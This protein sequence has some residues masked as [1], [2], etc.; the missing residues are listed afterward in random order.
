MTLTG[1]FDDMTLPVDSDKVTLDF[2]GL[3][4]KRQA[5]FTTFYRFPSS[6]KRP[7]SWLLAP[8]GIPLPYGSFP[9]NYPDKYFNTFEGKRRLLVYRQALL[10]G[11]KAATR[12]TTYLDRVYDIRQQENKCLTD[13]F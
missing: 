13:F 5:M 12:Q 3:I 8:Q 2:D 1:N 11:L 6:H 9:M 10:A 4:N 7:G